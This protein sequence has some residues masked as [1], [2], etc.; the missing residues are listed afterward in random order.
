MEWRE[1]FR[2]PS[3]AE[4]HLVRG[5]LESRG[6][7]CVLMSSRFSAQPLTFGALGE[8]K[9]LVPEDWH[10]SALAM[11]RRRLAGENG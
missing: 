2:T 3:E 7:P 11:I 6:V 1:C 5:F 9:V 8:I 10:A 4:A